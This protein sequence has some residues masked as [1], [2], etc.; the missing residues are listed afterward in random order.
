MPQRLFDPN[1]MEALDLKQIVTTPDASWPDEFTIS[2]PDV[3]WVVVSSVTKA[4]IKVQSAIDM[5]IARGYD[6]MTQ[7]DPQAQRTTIRAI[8]HNRTTTP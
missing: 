6:V 8:R 5:M 4:Q 1:A 2:I 7:Y 3:A